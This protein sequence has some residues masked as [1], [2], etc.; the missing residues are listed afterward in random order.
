MASN[1]TLLSGS[2]LIGSPITYQVTAATVS[3]AC[4]FHRVKLTVNG[5]LDDGS[6][7]L[8]LTL[9]SP[10][11]SAE[12]VEIDISSAL[13][14]VADKYEY[15]AEPPASYPRVGYTLSACDEYMQNG[16]VHDNVG[17]VEVSKKQYCLMGAY[18]DLERLLSPSGKQASVFTRKPSTMAEVVAVGETVVVPTTISAVSSGNVTT[19][20]SSKVYNVTQEGAQTLGGRSFYAVAATPDRYQFRFVNG[21]GVLESISVRSLRS[22]KMNV[23]EED[24]LRSVPETFGKFSRSI[25]RK[26]NDYETWALSSGPL[27][28][29]WLQWYLHEFLMTKQAWVNIGGHWIGC[30]I[31]PDEEVNGIDRT[32]S[33]LMSV[34]FSVRLDINGSPTLAI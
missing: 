6:S 30:H 23:T 16:E 9:S 13:R 15:S 17:V 1:L 24:T 32:G 25:V 22:T 11:E 21:L 28:A 19:T 3:G 8:S 29:A 4:A 2:P 26:S 31:L 14:A 7:S 27:D 20:P 10:V 12:T 33:N 5:F 18:S 34:S